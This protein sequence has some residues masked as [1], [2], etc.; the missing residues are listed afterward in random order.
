MSRVDE[1]LAIPIGGKPKE[2][3]EEKFDPAQAT[4]AKGRIG[5]LVIPLNNQIFYCPTYVMAGPVGPVLQVAFTTPANGD[6]E[7]AGIN[8]WVVHRDIQFVQV[9]FYT[10]EIKMPSSLLGYI[11]TNKENLKSTYKMCAWD[12]LL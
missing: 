1:S 7:N 5:K 2:Q 8:D 3:K 10:E 12:K 9:G 6:P 4:Y 11:T